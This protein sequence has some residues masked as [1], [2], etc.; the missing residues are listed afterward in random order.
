M[1]LSVFLSQLQRFF[2]ILGKGLQHVW[3]TLLPYSLF[4]WRRLGRAIALLFRGIANDPSLIGRDWKFWTRQIH[5]WISV[6]F[7]LPVII[8]I[9]TGMLLLWKKQ[10]D[11]VQPP[12]QQGSGSVPTLAYE[13]LLETVKGIPEAEIEDWSDIARLDIRPEKGIVKVRAKNR[14]EIQLDHQSGELLQVMYRRSDLIESIHDGAFFH[15]KAKLWVFFP[16]AL[17]L[18]ALWVTGL[19]L[20][21]YPLPGKVKKWRRG[22]ERE[23]DQEIRVEDP[24]LNL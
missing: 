6:S 20:F 4:F 11:W 2:L 15:E 13:R 19:I 10:S 22:M 14:W 24:P 9:C 1:N 5:Y 12:T 7:A 21:L 23:R 18:L 3:T 17:V 8:T 16:S